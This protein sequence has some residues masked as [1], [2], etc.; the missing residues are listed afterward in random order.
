MRL[1]RY[2]LL[3]SSLLVAACKPA[4]EAVAPPRVERAEAV[5]PRLPSIT[6]SGDESGAAAWNWQPP[7]P[8]L[9]T[10]GIPAAIREA[11]RALAQQ[12][13]YQDARD[14][15]PLYLAIRALAPGDEQAAVGLK[16]ALVPLLR[17]GDLALADAD[18]QAD[19]LSRAGEI[20]AVARTLDP[21]DASVVAYLGRV[22]VADQ[23]WRLN[24]EGER[25]LRSG[26]LENEWASV[27][28]ASARYLRCIRARPAHCRDWRRRRAR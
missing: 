14:A 13:L 7:Q 18:E 17:Q 5:D 4:P 10:E 22:D 20:A 24:A 19:A 23:L 26:Q 8:E 9:T 12:R 16:K 6:V 1:I 3:L 11:A 25:A 27:L 28:P 15:I 21:Q 2:L